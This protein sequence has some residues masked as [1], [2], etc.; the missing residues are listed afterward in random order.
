MFARL[1][2]RLKKPQ[3]YSRTPA[4]RMITLKRAD[5]YYLP[6]A[7]CGST[8]LKNLFYYLDNGG[9]HYSGDDIHSIDDALQRASSKDAEKITT[10][11]YAFAVV[12]HPVDRFLSYYFDKVYGQGPRSFPHH[13][14]YFTR[15]LGLDLSLGLD[16]SG[17]RNNCLLLIDWTKKNLAHKTEE[18]IN[19][20]W[21]RQTT[22]LKR[23]AT[24]D[25]EYLTLDGLDWQLPLFIGGVIPDIRD[26]M[27]AVKTRNK[28]DWPVD[29]ATLL[30]KELVGK[31]ENTYENDLKIY[32][33]TNRKWQAW[34][35]DDV[36]AQNRK[37]RV[38][39]AGNRPL[40]CV[41][42]P[43]VGCTY[44]KNLF[45]ILEHGKAY[46]APGLIHGSGENARQDM[47]ESELSG[48][49]SFFVVRDPA[50]RFFSLYFDKIYGTGP[51][52]FQWITKRLIEKRGFVA[53]PDISLKQHQ[54][55]CMGFLGYL[56]HKFATQD[57]EHLNPHWRPQIITAK[58]VLP[59]GLKPLLLDNLEEQLQ[60]IS[61]GQIPELKDAMGKVS[62]R[63]RTTR[64]YI[65]SEILTP[66]MA[67]RISTLYSDDQALY[68]RVK[69]GWAKTGEPPEL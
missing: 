68:E 33:E 32:H 2:K 12:R 4:Q 55:N 36:T 42:T 51:Q 47:S 38:I 11:G 56:E 49:A 37:L 50:D 17:H 5:I 1:K 48:T 23:V 20:H 43:K 62:D 59:F 63:N 10:S 61:G 24:L 21:R 67:Q 13:Q 29:R 52:A 57:P 46:H 53:G 26:A 14:K 60:H 8:Y 27:V 65:N 40:Y 69:S 9:E 39:S 35:Q 34:L 22:R 15:E 7:K 41:T 44:L 66:I 6:I 19:P 31:I 54:Q 3:S 16:V 58:R 28:T 64:A 18:P 30:D 25:L 45:Y